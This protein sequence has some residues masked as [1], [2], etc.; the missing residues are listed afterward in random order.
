MVVEEGVS[1]K[2]LET[3]GLDKVSVSPHQHCTHQW[4]VPMTCTAAKAAEDAI[5]DSMKRVDRINFV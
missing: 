2:S 1:D 5:M 4:S 3:Y